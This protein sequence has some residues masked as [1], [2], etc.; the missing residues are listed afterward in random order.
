MT[1][2]K[3]D[4]S[5]FN[6]YVVSETEVAM[7]VKTPRVV[8]TSVYNFFDEVD[9]G[10]VETNIKNPFLNETDDSQNNQFIQLNLSESVRPLPIERI[11]ISED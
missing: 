6:N 9:E 7:D 5:L 10:E 8:Q 4:D 11:V 1:Q 3:Q 2:P